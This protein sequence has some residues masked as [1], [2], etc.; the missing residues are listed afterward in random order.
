[1]TRSCEEMM[2]ALQAFEPSDDGADNV[3][4]LNE[5]LEGFAALARCDDVAQALFALVE[6]CPRADF[7]TPA[8]LVRALE[9]RP[10]YPGLLAGS[11]E[12]QPTE[13]GGWMANRLLNSPLRNGDRAAWLLRLTAVTTH[14]KADKSV[15]ESAIR[16]LD[17]QTSRPVAAG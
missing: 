17:F 4:W 5:T 8:P 14:P 13:L 6:R 7:G 9:A 16:F 10:A 2:A 11:L 1:M 3:H 12:R 15:R